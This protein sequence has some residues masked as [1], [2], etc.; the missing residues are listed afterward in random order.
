MVPRGIRLA[1]P[2]NIRHGDSWQGL[3]TD[4]PDTSFAKFSS[5][6]YGIRAMAKILINY[7]KKY[8]V[9]TIREVISRWAPAVENDT[10]AYVDHVADQVGFGPDDKIDLESRLLLCRLIAAI[11]RHENGRK[12]DGTDWLTA[13]QI[14]DGVD[15][16]KAA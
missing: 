2:G 3:S 1:N 6:E 4:Q 16:V 10:D 7:K 9:G 8:G 14:R 15:L 12:E 13:Q 5:P 11:S